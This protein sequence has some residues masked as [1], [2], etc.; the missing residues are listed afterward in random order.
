MIHSCEY[1]SEPPEPLSEPA[2]FSIDSLNALSNVLLVTSENAPKA[3][4]RTG[5]SVLPRG[6]VNY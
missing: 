2:K 4:V 5:L 1:D 6:I 3:D